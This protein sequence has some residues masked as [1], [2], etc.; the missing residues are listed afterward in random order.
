MANVKP[1]KA[2][3]QRQ[4]SSN[5]VVA[6]REQLGVVGEALT[7][8]FPKA[9]AGPLIAA[10]VLLLGV[11]YDWL[12]RATDE[13]VKADIANVEELGD[14]REILDRRD[15]ATAEVRAVLVE[16]RAVLTTFFGPQVLAPF[17]YFTGETP[18]DPVLVQRLGASALKQLRTFNPPPAPRKSMQFDNAEWIELLEKPVETLD[19]RLAEVAAD[20]RQDQLTQQAKN[21]AVENYDRAFKATTTLL[22]GV[23]TAVGRDDLASRV[24]PSARRPGR[25][26]ED[27][28]A[29]G[30]TEVEEAV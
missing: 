26:L 23:F 2:V 5:T 29:D 12:I 19:A 20:L 11:F 25:T 6:T 4:K 7:G 24:K 3:I 30:E 18:T 27:V 13:M 14:N 10:L 28:N 17:G 16:L 22:V 8:L 21:R 15:Q 1:M 9:P